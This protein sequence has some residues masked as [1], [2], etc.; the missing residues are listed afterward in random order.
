[1]WD[2]FLSF[3]VVK[4]E[5]PNFWDSGEGISKEKIMTLIELLMEMESTRRSSKD[6]VI[7]ALIKKTEQKCYAVDRLTWKGEITLQQSTDDQI[8]ILR[9]GHALISILE[10]PKGKVI[11]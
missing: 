4:K 1:M 8:E 10:D 2:R 11:K 7:L 3:F 6:P 5:P 9:E